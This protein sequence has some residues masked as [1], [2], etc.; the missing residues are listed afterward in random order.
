MMRQDC[1]RRRLLPGLRL[2][3]LSYKYSYTFT[4]GGLH[5]LVRKRP[6]K[7]EIAGSG[8]GSGSGSEI[9]CKKPEV[10]RPL[11]HSRG[12]GNPYRPPHNPIPSADIQ[13][14]VTGK[15]FDPPP[16]K[17]SSSDH[18]SLLQKILFR[19]RKGSIDSDFDADAGASRHR[20]LSTRSPVRILPPFPPFRLP[21]RTPSN[22]LP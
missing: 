4:A 12:D 14:S 13:P 6:V 21:R 11:R 16:G 3:R 10:S 18:S 1:S 15:T 2:G 8:S 20:A 9:S 5:V 7:I 17:A 19:V 22:C